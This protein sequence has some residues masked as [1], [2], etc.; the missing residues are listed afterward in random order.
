MSS[1]KFFID[2]IKHTP[3]HWEKISIIGNSTFLVLLICNVTI[4]TPLQ[5]QTEIHYFSH[6]K[7]LNGGSGVLGVQLSKTTLLIYSEFVEDQRA[8]K[9]NRLNKIRYIKCV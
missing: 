2:K 8:Q 1:K 3:C 9:N 6:Q 4:L 7:H 5:D